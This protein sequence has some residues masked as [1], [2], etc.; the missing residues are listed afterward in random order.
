MPCH[1]IEEVT[2]VTRDLEDEVGYRSIGPN[3]KGVM[4]VQ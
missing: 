2:M 3:L 4:V 1:L